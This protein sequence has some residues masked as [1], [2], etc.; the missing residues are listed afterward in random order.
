VSSRREISVQGLF[1]RFAANRAGAT[2]VEYALIALG[3]AFVIIAVAQAL[4]AS[5]SSQYGN[6]YDA[7]QNQ[8]P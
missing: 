7:L 8:R 2:A 6:V 3:I 1:L 5:A 4:G